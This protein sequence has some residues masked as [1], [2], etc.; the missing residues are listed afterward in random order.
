LPN[1]TEAVWPVAEHGYVYIVQDAKRAGNAL[2]LSF[3]DDLD[4]QVAAIARRGIQPAR[5]LPRRAA[6]DV[7]TSESSTCS[8]TWGSALLLEIALARC[9]SGEPGSI[10][11]P[12]TS[13]VSTR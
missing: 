3:V 7:G 1:D 4:D 5:T 12:L 9:A 13:A 11:V 6:S 8:I 10:A 2:V